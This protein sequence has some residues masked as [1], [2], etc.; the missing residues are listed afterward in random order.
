MEDIV[1]Y[2]LNRLLRLLYH[3]Y[4]ELL[5][6]EQLAKVIKCHLKF[7]IVED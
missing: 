5:I 1:A 7:K 3:Q 2:A 4:F 6:C